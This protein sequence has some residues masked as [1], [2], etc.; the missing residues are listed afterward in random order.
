MRG[1]YGDCG[2]MFSETRRT[3]LEGLANPLST[4]VKVLK[5]RSEGLGVNVTCRVFEI[6]KNSEQTRHQTE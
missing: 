5:A 3:F 1:G 4:I 6:A 2:Q